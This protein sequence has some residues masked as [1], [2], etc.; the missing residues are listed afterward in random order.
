MVV[1]QTHLGS[2]L[3]RLS[4]MY[5]I[6]LMIRYELERISLLTLWTE[7]FRGKKEGGGIYP[8]LPDGIWFIFRNH[9]YTHLWHRLRG[10]KEMWRVHLVNPLIF[11]PCS[12]TQ[13]P[14]L[15]PHKY[16][17]KISRKEPPWVYLTSVQLSTVF[18]CLLKWSLTPLFLF[19]SIY[20]AGCSCHFTI[21]F[22]Y[23][24]ECQRVCRQSSFLG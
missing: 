8:Q 18:Y 6:N 12:G 13:F 19:V 1:L 2:W 21:A 24:E 3:L 14:H 9:I 16:P 20:R 10:Q 17:K 22:T 5:G 23:L 11:L 7:H 4:D 15:F